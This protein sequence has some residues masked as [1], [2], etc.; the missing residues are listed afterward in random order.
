MTDP[1]GPYRAAE[2]VPPVPPVPSTPPTV[3]NQVVYPPI[4]GTPATSPLPMPYAAAPAYGYDPVS[5]QPLSDKSK[6]AAGLL[7]L[8]LGFFFALGGVGRLYAGHTGLGVVQ[9]VAT[10]FGW[11]SFW[12]GFLLIFP[13]FISGAVWLWFVI[14][15]I[16]LMAGRPVDGQGRLLRS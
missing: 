5:G 13:W 11:L 1:Y 8:L 2:P 4:S 10:V 14:D 7:Q 6:I 15:G 9:L 12:C 16:I 3:P